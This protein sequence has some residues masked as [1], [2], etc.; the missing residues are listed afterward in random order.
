MFNDEKQDGRNLSTVRGSASPLR[1]SA[2][3]LSTLP[4][5]NSNSPNVKSMVGKIAVIVLALIFSES[6]YASNSNATLP[7]F[8]EKRIA[9]L[10]KVATAKLE[11]RKGSNAHFTKADGP[12]FHCNSIV[13]G[14]GIRSGNRGLYTWFTCSA[15]HKLTNESI[16]NDN[17][18]CTGFSAPVWIEP[19]KN[20]I[21]VQAIT[22]EEQYLAFRASAPA[23]IQTFMDST[24]N[25]TSSYRTS[26]VIARA[27]Q[28]AK[29]QD[30][31]CQ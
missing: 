27:T 15:M 23:D 4:R 13:L 8:S 31:S 12:K 11:L 30:I 5:T 25:Q 26:V 6:A 2:Q 21:H 7:S 22:S 17:I 10:V 20:S 29:T 14:E 19:T 18:P 24:F 9:H 1:S 3:S 28:G 16:A